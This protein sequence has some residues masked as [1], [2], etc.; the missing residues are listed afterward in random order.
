MNPA[1]Q[2]AKLSNDAQKKKHGKNYGKEM[3][4]RAALPRKKRNLTSEVK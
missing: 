2:L 3:S 1:A 4:R